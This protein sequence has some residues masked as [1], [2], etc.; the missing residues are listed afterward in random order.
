M[1]TL[2]QL[3]VCRVHDDALERWYSQ[4]PEEVEPGATLE[5]VIFAQHFCNFTLWNLEDEARRRDVSDSVIA[6][7]KRAIDRRNQRRNDLVEKVDEF[8][9][10]ELPCPA[11]TAE[12]HSETAGMM[13]DRLS[14]LSLKIRHMGVYAAKAKDK[15]LESE[16]LAKREVLVAQ[17][18]DLQNCL[19]RLVEDFQA[20]RRFFKLYRQFK[21]YNDPRLNPTTRG[22][23]E[24]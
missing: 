17:R 21:A 23:S 11:P 16:C 5:S 20:G 13:V 7:V 2:N 1:S 12:Q 6:G 9:L 8:L 22:K 18:R 10:R 4:A 15:S 19:R 24:Q 3:D 14:I